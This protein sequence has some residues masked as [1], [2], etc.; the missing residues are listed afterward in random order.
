MKKYTLL[1]VASIVI[2]IFSLTILSVNN[3]YEIL[4]PKE[5]TPE[6][7]WKIAYEK[8]KVKRAMGYTKADKPEEFRKYFLGITT[9]F[10]ED[11][12]TYPAN[13]RLIEL[14][15]A[16][17]RNKKL[18]RTKSALNWIC[19]GPGN[20]GGRTRTIII[21]PDDPSHETWFAGSCGGGIWKTTDGGDSW[22]DL[23]PDLPNLI[24]TTMVMPQSSTNIIYAGT[25]ESNGTAGAGSGIFKSI[26]KGITWEQLSATVND[27][28]YYVNRL[29][30][31]PTKPDTVLAA[32]DAGILKSIDG[33][34]TWK[35]VFCKPNVEDIV[36]DPQDFNILYAGVNELA[37]FKSTDG[38]ETWFSSAE[39]IG[40]GR[41]FELTIS[42]KYPKYVFISVEVNSMYSYVYY[43]PDK[44]VTW[45]R[46]NDAGGENQNLLGGQGWFD[47]TIACHPFDSSIV[48]VGG[49]NI[50]QLEITGD[51]S[52]GTVQVS[53]VDTVNTSFLSF[54]NF[55]GS[56]LG[57][58]M[59]TGYDE[60]S[61]AYGIVDDDWTSVEIRF[62]PGISQKA[63]RFTVPTNGGTA[64]DG[65]A[66]V[67]PGDY[68][69]QDY[70]DVPFEVWDI[71][72]N[73]QLMA[74]F[75]DQERDG[76]YSLLHRDETNDV[77]WREYIFVNAVEYNESASDANI[78]L[79]GGHMYKCL[80]F[81]W[82]VL[83][84]SATWTPDNLPESK[85][86]IR[87][88]EIIFD[89]GITTNLTDAYNRISGNNTH[90][91]A[92]GLGTTSFPGLHPDH[93]NLTIIPIDEGNDEFIII[94]GNDGGL[95]RSDDGGV[96][97]IQLPTPGYITTQFYGI[98]KKP[99]ANEYFG[100]TQ[101]NG[102]FQSPI[103]EDATDSSAYTFRLS[104]DGFEALWN[105][106][107]P[108]KIIGSVF[109]NDFY[110]STN[111][112]ISWS[113]ASGNIDEDDGP[114]ISKL[115]NS[116]IQPDIIF[117]VGLDGV[118]K[119]TNFG[120][121][122][123]QMRSI[124]E[125]W[126]HENYGI[127]TWHDVE[128]SLAN[129]RYIW[130]GAGMATDVGF[131]IFLSKNQGL[132][133]KAVNEYDLRPLNGFASG[134]A[135]HPTND[136]I[137]YVMF[138]LPDEPKILR[139]EDLG[140]TWE[141]ISG[142]GTNSY[143]SNGFPDVLTHD[144]IVMP[145]NTDILWAG[146][147]IGIFESTDNGATWAYADNGFPAA[148]VWQM[149]IVDDQIVVATHGK[150]IWTLDVP[151]LNNVP[152]II[153]ANNPSE[154][155]SVNVK[156]NAD[157]DSIAVFLNGEWKA[158]VADVSAGTTAITFN[159]PTDGAYKIQAE[160]YVAGVNYKSNMYP[161]NI[162]TVD[163]D[164][165]VAP[166]NIFD[167][168]LFPNPSNGLLTVSYESQHTGL[169]FIN[170]Y[171]NTGKNVLNTVDYKAGEDFEKSLY[172]HH[173]PEGNYIINV[174][175]GLS[176]VSRRLILNK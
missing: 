77:P 69:Y 126:T 34:V 101:D 39:G 26:D 84:D 95:G 65:G 8:K 167:I 118:Y 38:G 172:L 2:L 47:N 27:N 125:G 96:T 9:H 44:A 134:I 102:S 100:G 24:V 115:A 152:T 149:I 12:S 133:F 121:T 72:N 153:S 41:R 128:V 48:F 53:H 154:L 25:G 137:A 11:E 120:S 86:V 1:S 108:N 71:T 75:R 66:G 124:S 114:F 151:E 61:N 33:G 67:P 171:D 58:G 80:Y 45:Y 7:L 165:L 94:N 117:A 54:V 136:N 98:A 99:G 52:P 50:W 148:A 88:S 89:N 109:H 129:H 122:N 30:V 56:Y 163:I 103:D 164:E 147:D 16:L 107:N 157:V 20:I 92:Q 21:D 168:E 135:T 146:T 18:K 40:R 13:Y 144:L 132:T 111:G 143:S 49:V 145:H 173:L 141:D 4:K 51:I 43:S 59:E 5:D 82:P 87:F 150:G 46:F 74:S 81:F 104:G 23:T 161:I 91:I 162:T 28:F 106:N 62:G 116:R 131:N 79:D 90:G 31:H 174:G 139:T 14:Q 169:V 3:K 159:K 119:N 85:I 15:K 32:T 37:I 166:E 142:F 6:E 55:G 160:S 112:G 35:R 64:G 138:A 127:T 176:N 57:G 22:T 156:V 175:D 29:V 78:A 155:V 63:H 130:A 123:W 105:T 158:S 76:Q 73:K 17:K 113:P 140:E 93:H 10:G 19:R 68:S 110:L 83:H 60:G 170:I 42:P 97:F 70:V 36:A